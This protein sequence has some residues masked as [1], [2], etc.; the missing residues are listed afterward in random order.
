VREFID[1]IND[2]GSNYKRKSKKERRSSGQGQDLLTP[3][4]YHRP[5]KE[6]SEGNS[7][8]MSSDTSNIDDLSE[9]DLN[10]PN[11]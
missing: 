11:N 1:R 6:E 8:L 7:I 4:R 10:P 5:E 2:F 3:T 9:D